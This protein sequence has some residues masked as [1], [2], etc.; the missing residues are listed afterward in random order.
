MILWPGY[1][2]THA[3][4]RPQDIIR[5]RAEYTKA[6]VIVHPECRPEV[7]DLADEVLST[8]GM[9]RFASSTDAEEI[10]VG[11]EIG[12]L[13]RLRRENPQK[14]FIPVSEQAICPQMKLCNLE[15]ILQSLREMSPEVKV[16]E[17]VRIRAKASVD[18]MLALV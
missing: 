4:I 13:Y 5:L 8:S 11:T 6:K 14:R 15:N 12:I 9:C 16:P 1:C 17:E 2:P 10:I 3:R 7:I 18:R